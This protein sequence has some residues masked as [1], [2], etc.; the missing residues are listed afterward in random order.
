MTDRSIALR[1]AVTAAQQSV[2]QVETL[3]REGLI[4]HQNVLDMQRSLFQ[5]QDRLAESEG[6][7]IQNLIRIYKAFG[8]GWSEESAPEDDS[9]DAV[10]AVDTEAAEG[11]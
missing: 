9:V 1:R 2:D 11:D 5:E 3:Y 7:L 8:G 6:I 10:D 4:N